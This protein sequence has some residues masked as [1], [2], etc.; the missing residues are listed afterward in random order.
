MVRPST[1]EKTP[2][3]VSTPMVLPTFEVRCSAC[4]YVRTLDR[5][6][7]RQLAS[8]AKRRTFDQ[9]AFDSISHRLECTQCGT[10][11]KAHLKTVSPHTKPLSHTWS[12]TDTSWM[13]ADV[14][15]KLGS[16]G[17]P[18]NDGRPKCAKCGRSKEALH[19]HHKYCGRCQVEREN[20]GRRWGDRDRA[21]ARGAD[22]VG[23]VASGFDIQ[24]RP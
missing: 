5:E 1:L 13:D 9:A 7:G 15:E 17:S 23:V 11:G 18:P 10:R 3:R 19:L 14:G 6:G 4:G 22:A 8:A 12:P 24:T 20:D 21:F 16:V 2:L